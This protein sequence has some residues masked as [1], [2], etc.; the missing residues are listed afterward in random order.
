VKIEENEKI[1]NSFLKLLSI[2]EELREKCPWDKNQTFES[3]RNLTIEETYELSEAILNKDFE[4]IKEELGDLLLHI[5]FYTK[6]ASEKNLFSLVDV[7]DSLCEKL[8]RR[9]PHVYGSTEARNETEARKSWESI[10]QLEK[11][12]E[13]GI[14]SSIPNSLPAMTKS[15]K[16]QEKARSVGFDWSNPLQVLVKV[17]EELDELAIEIDKN[18][19]KTFIEEEFGDLLFSLINLARFL[20]IH[21]D[22]ALEKTNKKFMERFNFIENQ[23][24]IENK[25]IENLTLKEM[26]LFWE[27]SKNKNIRINKD[28]N[29][30]I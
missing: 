28:Q 7:V 21:P 8:I 15:L 17:K 27:K 14:F 30:L 3:L 19:D 11:K 1:I 5:A 13:K 26:E 16:I 6:I 22:D 20:N 25:K 9:H 12:S 4:N 18:I 24:Q 10:K 2:V 29:D 23:A